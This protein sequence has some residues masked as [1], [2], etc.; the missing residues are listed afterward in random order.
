MCMIKLTY[1]PDYTAICDHSKSY[2]VEIKKNTKMLILECSEEKN[3][4]I[5]RFK[6]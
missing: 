4:F 3:T 1:S 2:S 6:M 5:I